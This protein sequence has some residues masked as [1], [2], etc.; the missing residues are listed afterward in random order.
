[1]A[2]NGL[3]KQKFER[4][5]VVFKTISKLTSNEKIYFRNKNIYVQNNTLKTSV[6][7]TI[8]GDNRFDMITNFNE[9]LDD[10]EFISPRNSSDE[11][12]ERV[13]HSLFQSVS[14]PNRGFYNLLETYAKDHVITSSLENIIERIN[15]MLKEYRIEDEEH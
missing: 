10:L 4:Y 1:M 14:S 13:K 3:L 7:R 6:D 12:I 8:S 5:I 9:I 15:T 2:T 11:L